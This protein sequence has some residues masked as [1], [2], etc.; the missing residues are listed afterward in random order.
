MIKSPGNFYCKPWLGLHPLGFEP[1]HMSNLEASS[2][3]GDSYILYVQHTVHVYSYSP[4]VIQY[5]LDLLVENH[6]AAGMVDCSTD[7]FKHQ[8]SH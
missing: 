1:T 3:I 5:K 8:L 7:F 2:S 4:T 6:C